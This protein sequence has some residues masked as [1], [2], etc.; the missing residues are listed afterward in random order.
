MSA[1]LLFPSALALIAASACGSD[2]ASEPINP[3][4]V[5]SSVTPTTLPGGAAST[6]IT[7]HGSGF[8]PSSRVRWNDGDRVTHYE[9]DHVLTADLTA[10]DLNIL[11]PDIVTVVN[12][13]PGGGTSAAVSVAVAYAV[14]TITSISPNSIPV[15]TSN[16]GSLTITITGSGFV[17]K[18]VVTF[19]S[20]QTVASSVN[21]TQLTINMP[22]GF[23]LTRG[24]FHVTVTNPTPAGGT[25]NTVDFVVQ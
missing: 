25:S 8:V 10:A 18:S 16:A 4:P 22:N 23:L 19:G 5:L 2:S 3:M 1:R 14:P 24:T 11:G 9:N 17:P 7:L 20:I 13:G 21:F 6:T 15:P 12:G